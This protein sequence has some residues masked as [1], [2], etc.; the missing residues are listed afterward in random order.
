VS[1]IRVINFVILC[2]LIQLKTSYY[3]MIMIMMPIIMK[4]VFS[5]RGDRVPACIHYTITVFILLSF[6]SLSLL[7][8][9]PFDQ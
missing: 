8:G 5:V 4:L 1:S 3:D 2:R 7:Q 6:C 9:C